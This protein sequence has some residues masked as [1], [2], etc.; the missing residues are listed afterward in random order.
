RDGAQGEAPRRASLGRPVS[1]VPPLVPGHPYSAGP[2]RQRLVE[3]RHR[4]TVLPAPAPPAPLPALRTRPADRSDPPRR[5]RRRLRRDG[6]ERPLRA[7]RRRPDGPDE[8]RVRAR[9]ALRR[10]R[11]GRSPLSPIRRAHPWASRKPP[12]ARIG[13]SR[14]PPPRPDPRQRALPPVA[15][16]DRSE[17]ADR[18]RLST[19]ARGQWCAVGGLH[20]PA[21]ACAAPPE[22]ALLEPHPGVARHR[23]LLDLHDPRA[24]PALVAPGHP[25]PLAPTV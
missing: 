24:L 8:L 18:R 21:S 20:P 13:R 10:G 3:P 11:G 25:A 4:G 16:L 22:R 2:V 9:P 23:L 12:L 6:A 17:G 19:L 1:P 15:G 5:L 14:R 7:E